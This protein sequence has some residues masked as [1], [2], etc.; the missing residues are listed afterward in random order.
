MGLVENKIKEDLLQSV[1]ADCIKIYEFLDSR[2]DLQ[3][4]TREELIAKMNTLNNEIS[5][6]LKDVRLS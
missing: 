6:L 5:Q 2:F 4:D 3:E 1:Y